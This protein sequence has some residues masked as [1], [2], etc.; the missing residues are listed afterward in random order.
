MSIMGSWGAVFMKDFILDEEIKNVTSKKTKVYLEEVISTYYNGNYRS[1]I[2]VLYSIV[3]F[4]LIQKLTILKDLYNDRK[5]EEILD[6]IGKKQVAG[7]RYSVI[8]NTLFERMVKETSLLNDIEKRQLNVLKDYRNLAAHPVTDYNYELINPTKEQT[9]AHIRNMFEAIFMKDAILSKRVKDDFLIDMEDYYTRNGI[10][11]IEEY[12]ND[13]YYS[14][15]NDIVKK[16]IFKNLWS[17]CFYQIDQ[18][19]TKNRQALLHAIMALTKRNPDFFIDLVEKEK[20]YYNSKILI[21]N[22]NSIDINNP[23]LY[24]RDTITALIYFICRFPKFYLLLNKHVKIEITNL[25]EKNIN[26][27]ILAYFTSESFEQHIEKIKEQHKTIFMQG[28]YYVD[29]VKYN[30]LNGDALIALVEKSN[31]YGSGQLTR[32]YIIEYFC[33]STNYY[34]ASRIFQE[35]I[36]PVLAYFQEVDLNKLITGMDS[37]NQI[38]DNRD[39]GQF[40][41]AI[42]KA[43]ESA[44]Y[45]L[46]YQGLKNIKQSI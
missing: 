29:D 23:F 5:A 39:F 20:H 41:S 37:N 6:D 28:R 25:C 18:Q 9:L 24:Y 14:R 17:I 19:T 27:C 45:K 22:T 44:G 30:S 10:I 15:F 16:Y 7:E 36:T 11:K 33:R 34:T 12:L 42:Q 46:Y 31:D 4:D 26:L 8:E 38:Y 35:V 13:K 43:A 1:C 40:L 21:S 2:V 32:E 3:I